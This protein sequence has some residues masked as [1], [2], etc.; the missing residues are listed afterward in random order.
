MLL[1]WFNPNHNNFY[2]EFGCRKLD[3]KVGDTNGFGHFL[4]SIY[5]QKGSIFI[6]HD[7]VRKAYFQKEEI[8]YSKKN[9]LI[10]HLI[11]FLDK[12]RRK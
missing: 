7:S 1:I 12:E 3:L 9:K 2:L 10:T 11:E 8:I 4:V 5:L 6:S